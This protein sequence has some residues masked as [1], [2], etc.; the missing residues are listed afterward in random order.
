MEVSQ[1]QLEKSGS[2]GVIDGTIPQFENSNSTQQPVVSTP[3]VSNAPKKP[4]IQPFIEPVFVPSSE[5][6]SD[7]QKL[8]LERIEH[9]ASTD[10]LRE[11]HSKLGVKL[12]NSYRSA[13]A[14]HQDLVASM[15]VSTSVSTPHGSKVNPIW[16]AKDKDARIFLHS[17]V[18]DFY[19]VIKGKPTARDM[20]LALKEEFGKTDSQSRLTI[21]INFINMRWKEGESAADFAFRFKDSWEEASTVLDWP[22]EIT[23]TF[24]LSKLPQ[25]PFSTFSTIQFE[26]KLGLEQLLQAF[27][28]EAPRIGYTQLG[29]AANHDDEANVASGRRNAFRRLD[30]RSRSPSRSK[31]RHRSNHHSRSGSA[32]G[33][34]CGYCKNHGH[35]ARNCENMNKDGVCLKCWQYQPGHSNCA[36]RPPKHFKRDARFKKKSKK[37]AT[38]GGANVAESGSVDGFQISHCVIAESEMELDEDVLLLPPNVKDPLGLMDCDSELHDD[39]IDNKSTLNYFLC[40]CLTLG[41]KIRTIFC[42]L[43]LKLYILVILCPLDKLIR[44]AAM[45]GTLLVSSSK[46]KP[47]YDWIIDSGCTEHMAS[48]ADYF[49]SLGDL[50]VPRRIRMGNGKCV[51]TTQGGDVVLNVQG[52]N[53]RVSDVIHV[54]E[55]VHNLIS[56]TALTE[57]GM[58]VMFKGRTATVKN[59]STTI[60]TARMK[61]SLWVIDAEPA[62]DATCLAVTASAEIWHQ[63]YNHLNYSDSLSHLLAVIFYHG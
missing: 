22:L 18:G 53:I 49:V 51:T 62:K 12:W 61:N 33:R 59:E 16:D 57:K 11:Q 32:E 26:K 47:A 55:L 19:R 23:R 3:I 7:V 1:L 8:Q 48:S 17:A 38:D 54:P 24:F 60:F 50:N 9:E 31:S 58:T 13:L 63:R 6:E 10:E 15:P 25:K 39:L 4:E 44:Q 40:F 36:G 56:V 46:R 5:A 45:V 2:W 30:H 34:K 52:E 14:A 21:I 28:L 43:L 29:R 41:T 27:R 20:W 42:A 37:P 35:L